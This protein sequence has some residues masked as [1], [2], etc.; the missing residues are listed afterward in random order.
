VDV[1]VDPSDEDDVVRALGLGA[2]VNALIAE[3]LDD[4]AVDGELQIL[5]VDASGAEPLHEVRK[6]SRDE[7]KA[8]DQLP[9]RQ[10]RG[11]LARHEPSIRP[12]PVEVPPCEERQ[13][14]RVD[15]IGVVVR[16]LCERDAAER[17]QAQAPARGA[18]H[19]RACR[20][21]Q[22]RQAVLACP[23]R[24]ERSD[25]DDLLAGFMPE[26]AQVERVRVACAERRIQKSRVL[27]V[28]GSAGQLGAL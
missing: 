21:R 15:D 4:P 18:G 17:R 10:R 9:R 14:L 7:L 28:V 1:R 26:S 20:A 16:D 24:L 13:V 22:T 27:Y 3:P 25:V 11:D 2:R 12:E 23:G 8:L 6:R 19:R 5:A